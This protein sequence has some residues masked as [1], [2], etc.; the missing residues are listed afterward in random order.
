MMRRFK[1]SMQ[2]EF[3]MTDLGKIK[4]LL[5]IEVLQTSQRIHISQGKYALEVLR[6]FN[7]ED[8]NAVHNPMVP[9][10]NLDMDVGGEQVDE[11][12]YKHIIGSLMYITTTRLDLQFAVSL[13]SRYMSEP[14][15]LHL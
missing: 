4:Y 6:R 8:C 13:L 11:T 2:R 9:G 10:S 3:D 15:Q 7:M 1:Q 12:F 14:T 5:R